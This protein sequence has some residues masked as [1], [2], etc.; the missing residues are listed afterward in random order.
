MA[1]RK[2][3]QIR[4]QK[5]GINAFI[6]IYGIETVILVQIERIQNLTKLESNPSF[7]L[8]ELESIWVQVRKKRK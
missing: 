6:V 7:F 4:R 3:V 1:K 2:I 5:L 8:A